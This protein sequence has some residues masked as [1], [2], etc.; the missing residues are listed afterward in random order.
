MGSSQKCLQLMMLVI[1][2]IKYSASSP[3]EELFRAAKTLYV[4]AVRRISFDVKSLREVGA[5]IVKTKTQHAQTYYLKGV[6]LENIE[7]IIQNYL[8][9][10]VEREMHFGEDNSKRKFENLNQRVNTFAD[11]LKHD[12]ELAS[13]FGAG[14][15]KR[16]MN[17][18]VKSVLEDSE[19]FKKVMLDFEKPNLE[20]HQHVLDLAKKL[21]IGALEYIHYQVTEL[22]ATYKEDYGS[23]KRS[24]DQAKKLL[25][26]LK[27][28]IEKMKYQNGKNCEKF[29]EEHKKLMEE[30]EAAEKVGLDKVPDR[31][32]IS[33][34]E[35]HQKGLAEKVA[36]EDGQDKDP[37][38]I[39]TALLKITNEV[40]LFHDA[41]L[42]FNSAKENGTKP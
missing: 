9:P 11:L 13:V 8:L 19:G 3:E 26:A 41:F 28:P 12:R 39:K 20:N 35:G 24:C 22:E 29:E 37:I 25:L 27:D 10:F 21:Y 18:T 30:L 1:F 7:G 34:K 5:D 36:V 4:G 6:L 33:I 15:R 23:V 2:L 40:K 38:S 14:G 32:N 42:T 31:E 17:K 16:L